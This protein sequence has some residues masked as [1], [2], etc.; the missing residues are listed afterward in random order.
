MIVSA[1]IIQTLSLKYWQNFSHFNM[2]ALV[3]GYEWKI[4]IIKNI[5]VEINKQTSRTFYHTLCTFSRS[6]IGAVIDWPTRSVNGS[7]FISVLWLTKRWK[8]WQIWLGLEPFAFS[9]HNLIPYDLDYEF[10][11]NKYC[12]LL[13][14]QFPPGHSTQQTLFHSHQKE[15]VLVRQ[16]WV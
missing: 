3:L 16:T 4:S 7:T 15:S 5:V 2:E 13:H 11:N 8:F 10:L 1:L 14:L 9:I 12:P 6:V